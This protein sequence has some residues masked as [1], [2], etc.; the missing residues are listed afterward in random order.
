MAFETFNYKFGPFNSAEYR[1]VDGW[2][3]GDRAV[4]ADFLAQIFKS[5]YRSGINPDIEDCLKIIPDSGLKIKR[6]A[7]QAAADGRYLLCDESEIFELSAGGTY[8][9]RF[10]MDLSER[11]FIEEIIDSSDLEIIRDGNIYDLITAKLTIPAGARQITAD[12]I[13]DLRYS[14]EMCGVIKVRSSVDI[15]DRIITTDD[16]I[17]SGTTVIPTSDGDGTKLLHDNGQMGT[18]D[19]I[20][21]GG[22]FNFSYDELKDEVSVKYKN[23]FIRESRIRNAP[24]SYI[25]LNEM[26]ITNTANALRTYYQMTNSGASVTIANLAADIDTLLK[27]DELSIVSNPTETKNVIIEA[28]TK[29]L[30][31]NTSASGYVCLYNTLTNTEITET[32]TPITVGQVPRDYKLILKSDTAE[33]AVKHLGIRIK[34]NCSAQPL[35]YFTVYGGEITYSTLIRSG[36]NMITIGKNGLK[37]NG[38]SIFED[39]FENRTILMKDERYEID[40]S[41]NF[42]KFTTAEQ[43]ASSAFGGIESDT[44]G[45]S[46]I[47]KTY[48]LGFENMPKISSAAKKVNI[49]MAVKLQ[50]STTTL[51][52]V[53]A[54]LIDLDTETTL[55]SAVSFSSIPNV[56]PTVYLLSL[57]YDN[58]TGK[59]FTPGLRL[60]TSSSQVMNLYGATARVEVEDEITPIA[61]IDMNGKLTLLNADIK[62][63][64]IENLTNGTVDI[65]PMIIDEMREIESGLNGGMNDE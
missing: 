3:Q 63:A 65:I 36:Q 20:S 59:T 17:P 28:Q 26:T 46:T 9:H 2:R 50:S 11:K 19:N 51:G 35:T 4:D 27:F 22:K 15:T 33:E 49:Q 58:S 55:A 40:Y 56:A 43:M 7:G 29:V 34:F 18:L 37:Y 8:Y 61:E 24:T 54:T 57:I 16:I 21:L 30:V 47:N 64:E 13:Q 23:E 38:F 42:D 25:S 44:Y 60:K 45:Q 10:R 48:S 62:N 14:D 31:T 5:M 12:M 32:L 1:D 39:K 41:G 6:S 52:S 53:S